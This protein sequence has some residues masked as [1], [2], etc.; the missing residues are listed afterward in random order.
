VTADAGAGPAAIDARVEEAL[1]GLGVPYRRMP[2]D[3]ALADTA[4]FCS[5][6][7][8]PPER[9]ANTIVV[10]SKK[11]PRHHAPRVSSSPRPASTSTTP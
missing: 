9:T 8:V 6:Y 4:A 5:H 11:E 1:A 10:A 3:P 7:G 2:C